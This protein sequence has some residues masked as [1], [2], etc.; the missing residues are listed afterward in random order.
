MFQVDM[1]EWFEGEWE[2][3][4]EE[5]TVPI[6]AD[7]QKILQFPVRTLRFSLG[8]GDPEGFK[9]ALEEHLIMAEFCI[10]GPQSQD[11][12]PGV[13]WDKVEPVI[14]MNPRVKVMKG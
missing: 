3:L 6:T 9:K 13:D 14:L 2:H 7:E 4:S 5:Q 8:K 11:K 10:G 1:D 12:T